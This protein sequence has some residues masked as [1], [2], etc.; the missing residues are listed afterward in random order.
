[1]KPVEQLKTRAILLDLDRDPAFDEQDARSL[2]AVYNGCGP[3]WSPKWVRRR[4]T[5]RF[6]MF[7]EAFLIHDW[8]FMYVEKTCD[9]F[10]LVNRRM[11]RN[12]RRLA[13]VGPW[14]LKPILYADAQLLYMAVS[15]KGGW[16]AFCDGS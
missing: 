2:A 8:D 14:Y 9:Q 12:C 5:S 16:E 13:S 11:L 1:M 15:S 6:R 7:E 4:L 3:E 10:Q